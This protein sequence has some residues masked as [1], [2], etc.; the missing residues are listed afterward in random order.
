MKNWH[1]EYADYMLEA[2][3]KFPFKFILSDFIGLCNDIQLVNSDAEK[4]LKANE[5]LAKL[6]NFWRLGLVDSFPPNVNYNNDVTK[7]L[8]FPDEI[9]SPHTRFPYLLLSLS[10]Q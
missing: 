8:Y 4:F 1:Q 5:K 2:I 6:S 10:R 9:I 3:P 7:S